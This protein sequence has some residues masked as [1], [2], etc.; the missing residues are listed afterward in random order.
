MMK[1]KNSASENITY[2]F[3]KILLKI[4]LKWPLQYIAAKVESAGTKLFYLKLP[5][6]WEAAIGISN[7]DSNSWALGQALFSVKNSQNI[8]LL[9]NKRTE[10]AL[11]LLYLYSPIPKALPREIFIF[12]DIGHL[13]WEKVGQSRTKSANPAYVPVPQKTW[14]IQ[15]F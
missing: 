5:S 14:I 6:N 7:F 11:F 13:Q 1:F 4:L 2:I 9:V 3:S 10:R 15:R 12:Y 8:I